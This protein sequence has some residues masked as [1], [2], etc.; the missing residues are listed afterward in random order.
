ML[1]N[2][3]GD[4]TN[5]FYRR[6]ETDPLSNSI[7]E[8]NLLEEFKTCECYFI[9]TTIYLYNLVILLG[10]ALHTHAS[11]CGFQAACFYELNSHSSKLI[12]GQDFDYSL[13]PATFD[14]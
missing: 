8:R 13:R 1:G 7:S 3:D 11:S 12:V 10:T 2:L 4:S 14:G 6:G 9:T 5:D